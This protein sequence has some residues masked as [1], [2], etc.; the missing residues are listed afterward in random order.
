MTETS[1]NLTAPQIPAQQ[2][3]DELTTRAVAAFFRA[4]TS[5]V[6]CFAAGSSSASSGVLR[7]RT[8]LPVAPFNGVWG[9]ESRVRT[10]DVLAAV[11]DFL[12]GELPWNL[13]LRPGYPSTLDAELPARGL[14]PTAQ[15]PFMVRTGAPDVPGSGAMRPAETFA[16]LDSVFTLLEQGF[17]MPPELS[18]HGFPFSMLCLPG[19]VTWI[20][21]AGQGDVA[22]ALGIRDGD[23][24]GIFNVATPAEHRGRGHGGAVTAQTIAASG[25]AAAYLQASPMGFPVYERLGFRTTEHW[26]Q[27]MPAQYAGG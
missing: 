24:C 21:S 12:A 22:T 26:Q 25:A 7:L 19:V 1:S 4:W 8:G 6:S 18:R 5:M 23:L 14:I 15:I 11:D 13:Q 9:T 27:W 10:S 2:P 3:V 16:D 20:A 17:G